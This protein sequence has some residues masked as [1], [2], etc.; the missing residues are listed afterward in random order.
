MTRV[1]I[2]YDLS[3]HYLKIR[4]KYAMKKVPNMRMAE[5]RA[6]FGSLAISSGMF[7]VVIQWCREIS[8]QQFPCF[9][10]QTEPT[11]C[12]EYNRII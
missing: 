6:V 2:S 3:I 1:T 7:W 12:R 11:N 5:S 10:S 9:K 8:Q 4:R